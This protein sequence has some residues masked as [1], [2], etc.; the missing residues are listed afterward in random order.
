MKIGKEYT[1]VLQSNRKIKEFVQGQGDRF[2]ASFKIV[3]S[4][5]SGDDAMDISLPEP[6][7]EEKDGVLTLVIFARTRSNGQYQVNSSDS[8]RQAIESKI[9]TTVQDLDPMKLMKAQLDAALG[10]NTAQAPAASGMIVKEIESAGLTAE[11]ITTTTPAAEIAV[12]DSQSAASRAPAGLEQ[13]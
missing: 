4:R 8:I 9:P 1:N 12:T 10:R 13:P 6:K 3:S 5:S 2:Q 11:S 7:I